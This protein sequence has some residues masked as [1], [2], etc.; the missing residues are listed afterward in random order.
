MLAHDPLSSLAYP[1]IMHTP[2]VA[3]NLPI[4]TLVAKQQPT[5]KDILYSVVCQHFTALLSL[6]DIPVHTY[7]MVELLTFFQ[8]GEQDRREALKRKL[9]EEKTKSKKKKKK[10]V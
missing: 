3:S 1:M 4:K 7:L 8:D 5:N 9:E 10:L 6:H 2:L